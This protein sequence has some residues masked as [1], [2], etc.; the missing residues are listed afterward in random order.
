MKIHIVGGFF[1]PYLGPRSNRITELTKEFIRLGHVVNVTIITETKGFNDAAYAKEIGINKWQN[2]RLYHKPAVG[3]K[4]VEGDKTKIPLIP[5]LHK[6]ANY[7]MGGNEIRHSIKINNALN[8]EEDT[9]MVIAISFP[10]QCIQGTS[11]YLKKHRLKKNCVLI[12]ESSDPHNGNNRAPW[13]KNVDKNAYSKFDY[14]TVPTS[15]AIP[16][17]DGMIPKDRIRVI[18]QGFNFDN[19]RLYTGE[20]TAPVK[21]AYS[22][23]F[24]QGIRDPEFLFSYLNNLSRDYEFHWFMLYEEAQW[25]EMLERYPNLNAKTHR[26]TSLDR[27]TLIYELSKMDFLINIENS[28]STQRPSKVIDYAITGRPILSFNKDNFKAQKLLDYLDG[29][30]H[31][32]MQVDISQYDIKNVAKQFLDLY[33]EHTGLKASFHIL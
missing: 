21:F 2:L 19:V 16:A 8:I 15:V 32:A 28:T 4:V 11:Y 24:F 10:F 3:E 30:Y 20:R 23:S 18:P 26:Y 29:N 25:I 22:G 9:D 5:T 12:A 13:F 33:E 6:W 7:L 17:Y 14:L 27:D 1:Y 31:D